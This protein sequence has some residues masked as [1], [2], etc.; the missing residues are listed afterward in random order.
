MSFVEDLNKALV[1]TLVTVQAA[2]QTYHRSLDRDRMIRLLVET[3]HYIRHSVPLM[4]LA[5]TH[6]TTP[7]AKTAAYYRH[8]VDEEKDH[9]VWLLE[10][11][12]SVEQDPE[13]IKASSPLR[14]TLGMVATQYY[15][16]ERVNPVGLL[17]YMYILEGMTPTPEQ[18]EKY[19][20][21]AD[22]PT[23]ALRTILEHAALDPHHIADMRDALLVNELTTTDRALIASNAVATVQYL[24][25][26]YRDL[27]QAAVAAAASREVAIV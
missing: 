9:D 17:G 27:D 13:A 14:P 25:D 2:W 26:M 16:I 3:Y 19:A 21:R 20:R 5:A 15:L 4:E 23:G 22:I 24:A 1:P 7:Q 11:L 10:D 18:V 12:A 6:C 8:H